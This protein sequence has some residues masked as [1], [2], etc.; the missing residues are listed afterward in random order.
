MKSW[1]KTWAG[2]FYRF[3][4]TYIGVNW[5]RINMINIIHFLQFPLIWVWN[6]NETYI[7]ILMSH[8]GSY[9]K[10]WF[11]FFTALYQVFSNKECLLTKVLSSFLS[12]VLEKFAVSVYQYLHTVPRNFWYSFGWPRKD[13]RLSRSWSHPVVFNTGSLD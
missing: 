10:V 7:W 13:E 4:G 9:P 5:E 8:G 6:I 1:I 12:L 2:G 11:I 3:L